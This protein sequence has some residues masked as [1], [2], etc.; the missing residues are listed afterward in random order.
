MKSSFYIAVFYSICSIV[1]AQPLPSTFEDNIIYLTPKI[2]GGEQ[3]RIYTDTGGGWNVISEE[4]VNKYNWPIHEKQADEEIV[5]LVK[6]PTFEVTA[7]IPLGG[8][9]NFMEGMLFI[10]PSDVVDKYEQDYDA[11]LGGRWHAEKIIQLNYLTQNILNLQRLPDDIAKYRQIGVGFQKGDDGN[12][13]TAFPSISITIEDTE[14]KMLLD[15]GAMA[16]PREEFKLALNSSYRR[17]ATSFI[18]ESVFH[19]WQR[20]YPNW[21]VLKN[22]CEISGADM[23]RV[24][25]IVIAG[26][27]LGPVWFT[28][29]PDSN[30]HI[31]MSSMM[32]T[33][34]DGAL[35][36]SALKYLDV[37]VD[38]PS[39]SAYIITGL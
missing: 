22:A 7:S 38:Y 34:V 15:T 27:I 12:Y 25:E 30:F 29:R 10:A 9:N 32:D 21:L 37:I 23:I 6:M 16:V 19:E 39:E 35:G 18:V 36:G 11:F 4:L 24:P 13:T 5:K 33:K 1:F 17:I 31:Y 2:E 14:Y 3:L 8:L 28:K 20:R 26:Q